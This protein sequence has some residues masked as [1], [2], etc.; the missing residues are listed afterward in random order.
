MTRGGNQTTHWPSEMA[1]FCSLTFFP[2]KETFFPLRRDEHPHDA[3][4]AH[5]ARAASHT[6][7]RSSR[8]RSVSCTTEPREWNRFFPKR[9]WGGDESHSQHG[10]GQNQSSVSQRFH[11]TCTAVPAELENRRQNQTICTW[12]MRHESQKTSV[13]T[14]FIWKC[15]FSMIRLIIEKQFYKFRTLTISCRCGLA[16]GTFYFSYLGWSQLLVPGWEST[17]AQK[18]L[19]TH[20][21]DGR[22]QKVHVGTADD[23]LRQGNAGHTLSAGPADHL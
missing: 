1:L 16:N 21:G 15:T 12:L 7:S 14:G 18:S 3:D 2:S 11:F 22:L 23:P 17:S 4:E 9:V 10:W 13:A 6:G 20:R 19:R 5:G 8:R